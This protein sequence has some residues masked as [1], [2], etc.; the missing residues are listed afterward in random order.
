MRKHAR[1]K[2][3]NMTLIFARVSVYYFQKFWTAKRKVR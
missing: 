2:C 3:E 1:S